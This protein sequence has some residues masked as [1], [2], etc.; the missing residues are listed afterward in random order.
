MSERNVALMVDEIK[1]S[2]ERLEKLIRER[3]TQSIQNYFDRASEK[4][5]R[6]IQ[7]GFQSLS[8]AQGTTDLATLA[9][10]LSEFQTESQQELTILRQE[11][12]DRLDSLEKKL[13]ELS[14]TIE[15][16][17]SEMTPPPEEPLTIEI[18]DHTT[19]AFKRKN[20]L[21]DVLA[22]LHDYLSWA[23]DPPG[24]MKA[25]TDIVR[26]LENAHDVAL[27][28]HEDGTLPLSLRNRAHEVSRIIATT[29]KKI[30]HSNQGRFFAEDMDE[31]AGQLIRY[32][33]RLVSE[34]A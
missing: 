5:R 22:A 9:E 21:R 12:T 6:E 14:A 26:K 27:S 4:L 10:G 34:L 1:S 29:R 25:K 18:D 20:E 33:K 19:P 15:T 28:T 24:D 8:F 30:S 16:L 31:I 13:D 17:P 7:S 2:L 3:Y 23:K 11:F 32:L